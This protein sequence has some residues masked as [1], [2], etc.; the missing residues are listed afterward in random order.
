MSRARFKR[1]DGKPAASDRRKPDGDSAEPRA[2]VIADGEADACF[3]CDE[4]CRSPRNFSRGGNARWFVMRR[5]RRR[6]RRCGPG[7]NHGG[8]YDFSQRRSHARRC[9]RTFPMATLCARA[10][11]ERQPSSRAL[12]GSWLVICGSADV[13]EALIVCYLLRLSHV[14]DP[15]T[16]RGDDRLADGYLQTLVAPRVRATRDSPWRATLTDG[17]AHRYAHNLAAAFVARRRTSCV[18][19]REIECRARNRKAKIKCRNHAILDRIG[20]IREA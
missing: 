3:S 9:T 13:D 1:A 20:R 4:R 12:F 15:Q 14:A 8:G 19:R 5:H 7:D 17:R 6:S 11:W 18:H 10:Q 16:S 2:I